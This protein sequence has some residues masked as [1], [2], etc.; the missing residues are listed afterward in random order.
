MSSWEGEPI[1][2]D[3]PRCKCRK[4][5]ADSDAAL[6]IYAHFPELAENIPISIYPDCPLHGECARKLSDTRGLSL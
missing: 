1:P 3:D 4:G 2:N 5:K 6:V